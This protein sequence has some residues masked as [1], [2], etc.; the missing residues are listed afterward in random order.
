MTDARDQ[1]L[2]A[3][4]RALAAADVSPVHGPRTLHVVLVG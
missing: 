1:I 2:G 3:V 4:R